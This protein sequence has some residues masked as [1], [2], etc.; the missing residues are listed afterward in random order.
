MPALV[1]PTVYVTRDEGGTPRT[2][3]WVVCEFRESYAAG[4]IAFDFSPYY[5]RVVNVLFSP[6]SGSQF[7]TANSGLANSAFPRWQARA[8]DYG[9][10]VSVR[11]Q[12]F[13]MDSSGRG[14]LEVTAVALS[15]QRA[16]AHLLGY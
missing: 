5:R 7:L 9:T 1:S 3:T 2:E 10:P 14:E 11:L 6:I 8:E 15:G 16:Q 13:A 12:L 4:G